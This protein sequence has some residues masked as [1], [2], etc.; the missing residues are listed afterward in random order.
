VQSVSNGSVVVSLP[1]GSNLSMIIN[2]LT[3]RADFNGGLPTTG[4][5]VKVEAQANTSDG[6][7]TATKLKPAD[8]GNLQ[9]Q[10]TVD[11]EGMTTSTV[12]S[13]HVIHFKVGSKSFSFPIASTA[14]L[15]DFNGSAQNIQ[16]N[17]IVK[18][19][20]QYAGNSGTV[21]KVS[22]SNGH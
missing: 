8:S 10:S 14:D 20:V 6:S 19:K 18:V 1:D 2:N 21:I 7:F 13:D 9:D 16:N 15:S 5:F 3:D 17:T 11:I 4:Q 22:S 12:G